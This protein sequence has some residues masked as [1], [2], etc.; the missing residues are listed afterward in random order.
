[1]YKISVLIWLL[2]LLAVGFLAFFIKWPELARHF[3]R[4]DPDMFKTTYEFLLITVVGGGVTLLFQQL[5]RVREMRQSL[6]Q[7]HGE[8]L[9][10]FN[11]AKSVRRLLRA[12]LGTAKAIDPNT[13]ITAALYDDQM[14]SLSDAQLTFEVHAK[15]AKDKSLWFWGK[16]RLSQPLDDIQSYLDQ[17]VKEYE[18][19]RA[20][21]SGE[22]LQCRLGDLPNLAEFVGPFKHTIGFKKKFKYPMRD[23]LEALGKAVLR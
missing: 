12:Q 1:M 9:E 5:D 14:E 6:R 18:E 8:L 20:S 19:K 17:I 23:A 10:A 2:V 3:L 22:P 16:P 15:R 4:D 21:F 13:K 11:K 7:M